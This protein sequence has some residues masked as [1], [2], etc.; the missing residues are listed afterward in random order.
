MLISCKL[1]KKTGLRLNVIFISTVAYTLIIVDRYCLNFYDK[2]W[3]SWNIW[4][5]GEAVAKKSFWPPRLD[6]RTHRQTHKLIRHQSLSSLSSFVF[7][8]FH[9]PSSSAFHPFHLIFFTYFLLFCITFFKPLFHLPHTYWKNAL[10]SVPHSSLSSV[11]LYVYTVQKTSV[12]SLGWM[13]KSDL[14]FAEKRHFYFFF[15]FL[16]LRPV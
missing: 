3:N 14:F 7:A 1:Y 11:W 12:L 15:F 13:L 8:F 5:F 6:A 4:A 9:I 16:L 10:F 2:L